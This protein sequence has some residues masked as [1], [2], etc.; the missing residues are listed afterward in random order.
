LKSTPILEITHPAL[1]AEWHPTKNHRALSSITHGSRYKA[2]WQAACGHEWLARVGDRAA[3]FYNTGVCPTCYQL[4]SGASNHNWKGHGE[5]SKHMWC[6]MQS[7]ARRRGYSFELT[8]EEAWELFLKQEKKC[9]LTGTILSMGKNRTASLDRI[10]NTM[11]YMTDNVQW[12]HKDINKMK[13][14]HT[15][16]KFKQL[17]CEVGAHTNM[18]FPKESEFQG[19]KIDEVL[20]E[21]IHFSNESWKGWYKHKDG[22]KPEPGETLLLC[23]EVF[24]YVNLQMVK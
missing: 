16:E 7:D 21:I 19:F 4:R 9:R 14:T 20:N 15:E 10:D 1:A 5:I 2:W 12:L 11:G 22:R 23:Y 6:C 13:L 24:P 17:C 18:T 8:I 3:R